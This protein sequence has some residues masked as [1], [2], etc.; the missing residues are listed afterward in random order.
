MI[1]VNILH[2]SKSDCCDRAKIVA[3]IENEDKKNPMWLHLCKDCLKD[4]VKKI[5]K[6]EK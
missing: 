2:C 4:I 3:E 6:E 1:S 5:E